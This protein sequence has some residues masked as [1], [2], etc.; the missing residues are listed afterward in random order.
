M[1][2]VQDFFRAFLISMWK[3]ALGFRFKMVI[4]TFSSSVPGESRPHS[5]MG[6]LAFTSPPGNWLMDKYAWSLRYR[7]KTSQEHHCTKIVKGIIYT[8]KVI[9][10]VIYWAVFLD[11]YQ[12]ALPMFHLGSLEDGGFEATLTTI[13]K[14]S[15]VN[16]SCIRY[17]FFANGSALISLTV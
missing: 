14:W 9:S 10:R 16:L 4:L 13:G 12:S 3:W 7:L 1:K 6:S 17:I 2:I 11:C 5:F 15:L 8:G